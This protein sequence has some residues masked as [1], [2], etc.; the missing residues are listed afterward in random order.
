MHPFIHRAL[1]R[2]LCAGLLAV[3][4]TMQDVAG[5]TSPCQTITHERSTY[6]VCSVDL[7]T[8]IIQLF[9]KRADGVDYRHLDRLP[10]TLDARS[11][12][13]LFATN[14]GMFDPA[15]RPVGLYV[16]N[17]RQLV[18]ANTRS[19]WGN[20]HMK[21]NGVFYSAGERAGVLETGAYLKQGLHPGMATQSGPMLVI[22]GKLHPRFSLNNPSLKR[23]DGVGSCA[24]HSVTF[25][26]SER[27]VSFDAFARL[28]R[29]VLKCD[30][31]LFLDGGSVPS[32]Y[33]PLLQR[34]SNVLPLGPM[35]GV[36]QKSANAG[37]N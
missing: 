34:G 23:R 19:G 21:P 14:A 18:G 4:A 10:Q 1:Q 37:R 6:T 33:V 12:P 35:I 26:I 28:F 31:A 7:H 15:Y 29:D 5:A 32:L 36:Y 9:W 25:A 24:G 11:G 2:A 17:G 13:L 27:E 8:H 20:F 3:L 16:E 22:N 30:N